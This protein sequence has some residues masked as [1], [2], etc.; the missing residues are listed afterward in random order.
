MESGKAYREI[1]NK[2]VNND[3]IGLEKTRESFKKTI[4]V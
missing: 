3:K 2:I 4:I 1:L